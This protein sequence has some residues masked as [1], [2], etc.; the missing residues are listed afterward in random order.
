MD[1]PFGLSKFQGNDHVPTKEEIVKVIHG[2]L[3]VNTCQTTVMFS[4]LNIKMAKDLDEAAKEC[5]FPETQWIYIHKPWKRDVHIHGGFLPDITVGAI[6][7][8]SPESKHRIVWPKTEGADGDKVD[9]AARS[10][11]WVSTHTEK[12]PKDELGQPIISCPQPREIPLKIYNLFK[13]TLPDDCVILGSG[14]GQGWVG[15]SLLSVTNTRAILTECD[16][17]RF[18][19][20][21]ERLRKQAVLLDHKIGLHKGVIERVKQWLKNQKKAQELAIRRLK[22]LFNRVRSRV[23]EASNLTD[24]VL[25][26]VI[27]VIMDKSSETMDETK[28]LEFAKAADGNPEK[29]KALNKDIL[30]RETNFKNYLKLQH[31]KLE[32]ELEKVKEKRHQVESNQGN[33]SGVQ[34]PSTSLLARN[35]IGESQLPFLNS[36]QFGHEA[37]Y[38]VDEVFF[39]L[40]IYI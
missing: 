11:L 21:C 23:P 32:Q 8:K 24:G 22:T 14:D 40:Y 34:I 29:E 12:I 37:D 31:E 28:L 10:S 4:L 3:S 26:D 36:V 7:Y 20:M 13:N 33:L 2:A 19:Y 25:Q 1:W 30:N 17:I 35:F 6:S 18:D 16:E 9:H 5:G 38:K 27:K 39:L 15:F